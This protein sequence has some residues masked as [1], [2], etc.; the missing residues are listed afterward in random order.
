MT[1]AQARPQL[2]S[3]PRVYTQRQTLAIMSALMLGMGLAALDG[4]I[5]S[6]ALTTISRDFHRP[7]L[8]SWV[9]TSYLLTSTVTTPLYG[10]VSDQFGRKRIFQFAI[11]VFLM[12]SALS[13]LSG[14]MYQLIVFRGFQGLGAGGLMS[15][16]FSIVADVIP[17]RERGRYQGYFG[18]VFGAASVIGPL[19]GGFLVDEASWRWV[20]YVNLP[21]GVVTLVVINKVLQLDHNPRRPKIDFGG[22][23][24]LVAG[25]ALLLVG[26]QIIGEDAMVTHTAAIYGAAGLVGIAA[27]VYWEAR[28]AQEPIL[29]LGLLRNRVFTVC[30]AVAITTGA[31]VL[32]ATI[33]LP[34]YLQ[35]TRGVSPTLSGIWLLPLLGG[36]I[37]TS[38][39]SGRIVTRTGRYKVFVVAGVGITGI[40]IALLTQITMTT[41]YWTIAVMVFVS[42]FGS[43]MFMQMLILVVQNAVKP[44]ELGVGTS[45]VTFFRSL[46]GAIGASALG[47]ILIARER[48]VRAAEIAAHGPKRGPLYGFTSGMDHAFLWSLPFCVIA[49]ALTFFIREVSLRKS[50]SEVEP[51]VQPTEAVTP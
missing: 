21:V 34:Q 51:L 29:P 41:S 36:T 30:C 48:T 47:A 11:V 23:L 2:G 40:G 6:T 43:G 37:L 42:G 35:A 3:E 20:F 14:S 44:S 17:P 27:F 26:V 49:F 45:S 33:F 28:R 50:A 12:G 19:V 25:V 15:L 1:T 18:A 16:A 13:G 7:D 22:A 38:T 10:K 39:I 24:L 31:I 32:G 8:Y 46:G 9:V 5:V 4:T